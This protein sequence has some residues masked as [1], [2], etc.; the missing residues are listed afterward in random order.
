MKRLGRGARVSAPMYVLSPLPS[1]I[2]W[3]LL[4]TRVDGRVV[5]LW[6]E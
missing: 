5:V 2:P 4:F 1:V 6:S 3:L